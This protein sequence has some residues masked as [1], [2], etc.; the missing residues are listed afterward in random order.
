MTER[1]ASCGAELFTGQQFC[2]LCGAPTR[3]F[4]SGEIPTQILPGGAARPGQ[5]AEQPNETTPLTSRHTDETVYRPRPAAAAAP[6]DPPPAP[7]RESA[8]APARRGSRRGLLFALLAVLVVSVGA[9]VYIAREITKHW[10][11]KKAGERAGKVVVKQAGGPPL[12][13]L[14]AAAPGE[15]E[16]EAPLDEEGAEVSE[17]ET[18]I[19]ESFP[20]E[21]GR[22]FAVTN[23]A[24]DISVEG[25]DEEEVEVRI[26]K[27][28]GTPAER[29]GV[30][31]LHRRTPVRLLLTTK[32]GEARGVRDVRYEIKLPRGLRQVDIV[33]TDSD[34]SVAGV[35]AN[36]GIDVKR[37]DI[38][39]EGLARGLSTYTMKGNTK[40]SLAAGEPRPAD[41]PVIVNGVD[42]NVEIRLRPGAN[43]DVKA[44][45]LGGRIE[46]EEA[47]A[48][49]ALNVQRRM[50][51][52]EHA[53]G[54]LGKGGRPILVK[55]VSGDIKIK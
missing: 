26:T 54:R 11:V 32:A 22:S 6:N 43:A 21:A 40:V 18:V 2:R 25:W 53:A 55:T 49:A 15:D 19:T 9:S 52:G 24:G 36:V 17:D 30:E 23:V 51:G 10:V 31:I 39:V 20:L 13:P 12:P 4:N 34:V 7:P 5:P 48:A 44:E 28:G 35:D 27:R 1:C 42:G 29:A 8:A 14:P 50:A 38:S 3:A 47:T 46:A 16:P 33:S 37:G 41:A 45:T